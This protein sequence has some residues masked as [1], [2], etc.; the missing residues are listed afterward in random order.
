MR[1]S[2][3]VFAFVDFTSCY[4]YANTFLLRKNRYAPA[5]TLCVTVLAMTKF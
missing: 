2:G 5:I 4:A 1:A 3:Y